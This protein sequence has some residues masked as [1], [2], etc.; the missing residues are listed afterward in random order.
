MCML[1]CPQRDSQETVEVNDKAAEDQSQQNLS[2]SLKY[3]RVLQNKDTFSQIQ[4]VCCFLKVIHDR[5][6]KEKLF[7]CSFSF[8]KTSA[9]ICT[10]LQC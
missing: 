2:L 6:G 10:Y 3:T 5:L 4:S 9:S 7:F 1:L 8:I